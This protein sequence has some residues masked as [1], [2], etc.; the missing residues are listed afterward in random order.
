MA[1]YITLMEAKSAMLFY[2]EQTLPRSKAIE[3]VR[4][5]DDDLRLR[6]GQVINFFSSKQE[7]LMLVSKYRVVALPTLVILDD[8]GRVIMRIVNNIEAQYIIDLCTKSVDL[9][10]SKEI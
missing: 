10:P 9:T 7:D 5:F 6:N 3:L 8:N 2:S 1:Y 4:R